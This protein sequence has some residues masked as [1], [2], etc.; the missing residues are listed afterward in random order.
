MIL[1]NFT[2]EKMGIDFESDYTFPE[3][4]KRISLFLFGKDEVFSKEHG[5]GY[6]IGCG[7]NWWLHQLGE[8]KFRLAYR[9]GNEDLKKAYEV[10]LKHL[11]I[12]KDK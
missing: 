7:N 12:A 2:G 10:V 6:Q 1:G 4:A 8:K 3:L 11:W 5:D 9:Y